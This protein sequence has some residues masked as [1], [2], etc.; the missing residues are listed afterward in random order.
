MTTVT[1]LSRRAWRRINANVGEVM[2][3]ITAAARAAGR[4]PSEV[5]LVAV[6]KTFSKEL[7][8]AAHGAGV[9]H[10]GENWVQEAAGETARTRLS[11]S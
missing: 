3:R 11:H 9:S 1:A 7:V 5:T 6:S 8:E 10:F 2:G 4:D